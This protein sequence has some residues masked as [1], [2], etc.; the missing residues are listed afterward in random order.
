MDA[1]KE[2]LPDGIGVSIVAPGG[3]FHPPKTLRA[4]TPKQAARSLHAS[5]AR[6]R[7]NLGVLHHPDC[8]SGRA[9]TGRY[10]APKGIL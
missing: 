6:I 3:S 5:L 9:E 4:A 10:L 1:H 8:Q 7:A 2:F